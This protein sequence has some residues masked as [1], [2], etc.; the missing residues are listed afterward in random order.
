MNAGVTD[1]QLAD[2]HQY[3]LHYART[4]PHSSYRVDVEDLESAALYGLALAVRSWNP[5]S[6]Q[7]KSW[8]MAK[9]QWQVAEEV[10]GGRGGDRRLLS[11]RFLQQFRLV[12]VRASASWSTEDGD[13]DEGRLTAEQLPA[14]QNVEAEVLDRL[15]FQ[16]V[17]ENVR[18]LPRRERFVLEAF[19][20]QERTQTDI[21][22]ELDIS[23]SRVQ[24]L[25]EQGVR[26]LQGYLQLP[27][28]KPP[29]LQNES[30]AR[31]RRRVA[32]EKVN[33][34]AAKGRRGRVTSEGVHGCTN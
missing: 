19:Y 34:G 22:R 3:A 26:R 16:L 29:R 13:P 18:L 17:M 27:L 25:R 4:K 10:R 14:D 21:A 7:W 33:A 30:A 28:A 2:A 6:S 8:A 1:A 31:S 11:K 9:I 24:Q 32:G 15:E 12:P 20:L 23:E 5:S